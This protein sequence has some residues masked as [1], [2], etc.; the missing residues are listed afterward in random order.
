[1]KDVRLIDPD[2]VIVAVNRARACSE[3]K[4]KPLNM[5]R[6]A[7]ELG[8]TSDELVEIVRELE[9]K[10]GDERAQAVCRAIKMAKQETRADLEDCLA[11]KGNTTG[12]MFLAKCNHGMV[13]TSRQEVE[14]KGVIFADESE[15]PD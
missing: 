4:G 9:A 11:D 8:L 15:V 10:T 3:A 13:E 12:Y 1:M 7:L 14:F 6:V 5:A 2:E